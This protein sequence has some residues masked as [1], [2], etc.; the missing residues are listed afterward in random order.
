[1]DGLIVLLIVIGVIANISKS[2][3]KKKQAERKS[4]QPEPVAPSAAR[5]SSSRRELQQR[6]TKDISQIYEERAQQPLKAA[7][8]PKPTAR[9]TAA[10]VSQPAPQIVP[11]PVYSGSL[12]LSPDQGIEGE[13][14]AEHAAHL[15]KVEAEQALRDSAQD[16]REALAAM[17]LQ[18]LRNAVVMKEILDKPVSLRPRGRR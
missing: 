6:L 13:T 1:M 17:N 3:K 9:K 14:E 18:A 7:P 16:A 10:P 5:V 12:H 15:I 2:S 11:A 4:A 8:R